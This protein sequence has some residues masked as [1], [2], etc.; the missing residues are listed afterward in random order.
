MDG[1]IQLFKYVVTGE[2]GAVSQWLDEQDYLVHVRN[3]DLSAW[4]EQTLL[5]S[6]AKHGQQDVVR[7]LVDRGAEVYSNPMASYPAI[8]VAAWNE[9][10]DIVDF[11]SKR[12]PSLHMAPT[13]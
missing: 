6:A 11:F 5:H 13:A 12:F 9:Q 1:L 2:Y 8:I 4:D 10:P 7:L 3:P